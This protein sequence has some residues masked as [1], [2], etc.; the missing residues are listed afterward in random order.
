MRPRVPSEQRFWAKVI[1]RG[2][3]ECWDWTAIRTRNGYGF[4]RA[5]G[6]V[7]AHR[8]SYQQANGPIPDCVLRNRCGNAAC[9]NPKHWEA[10]PYI[11]RPPREPRAPVTTS[12]RFWAKVEKRGDD[13]CW[14]WK[15]SQNRNGYGFFKA[16]GEVVAHRWSFV[17]ARG[18]IPP[19]LTLDHLCR[20]RGCVNPAHL[21]IVTRGE[22]VLRGVG[23]SAAN[24]R[25]THCVHGHPFNEENTYFWRDGTS[26]VCKTCL[27][28]RG[29]ASGAARK[30]TPH[31]RDRTHCPRGHE[32]AGE[33]LYT[34]PDG[35][36]SCRECHRAKD[37]RRRE[38]PPGYVHVAKRRPNQTLRGA[39]AANA[40]KDVCKYGHPLTEGNF[41]RHKR[42]A[43]LCKECIRIR[44]RAYSD[45]KRSA[46][47][48]DVVPR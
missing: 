12:E 24:A 35:R 11:R 16:D 33:N 37:R 38:R 46:G 26:R 28:E 13:Q 20:N 23:L 29:R 5:D 48:V 31:S 44:N 6:Q 19:G 41:Y 25:K 8:W 36:R 34:A 1:R 30:T 3:D 17:Q 7:L 42:G 4:F 43:R 18:P 45:A 2:D 40:R 32:Y 39:A 22:N 27:A 21:E 15:A 14:D 47:G 9:V 10:K